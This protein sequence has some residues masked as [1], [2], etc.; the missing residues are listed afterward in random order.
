MPDFSIEDFF[1][2]LQNYNL[3]IWP[4]Q[5]FAY[6][7][8]ALVLYF[9]LKKSKYSGI[10][11]LAVLSLFWLMNGII[12]GFIYWSSSHIFGYVFG[13]FCTIQGILFLY[14][15]MKSDIRVG[16]PDRIYQF[17]G[18]LFILYAILGY[19]VLGYYLGHVYPKFFPAGL[20]PCPT[21]ILTFGIFLMLNSRI[22]I[23]Y[24]II[25]LIIS[26]G[27]FLAAYN[28]I[29]ED[30]G[31]I[32]TGIIGTILIIHRNTQIEGKKIQTT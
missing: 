22:S 32:L 18:I 1:L 11:I 23:T 10:I 21:T 13:F 24:F 30:M 3:D 7:L 31:L 29:Y 5:I 12:F 6:V 9:L 27:G 15:I 28:G 25:P 26:L 16:S 8:I 2:V 4:V 17:I 20:V 19:Q 14:S